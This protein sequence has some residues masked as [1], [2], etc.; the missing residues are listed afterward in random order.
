M[1]ARD[2]A[3]IIESS[4]QYGRELLAGIAKYGRLH[5]WRIRY[6]QGGI[7]RDEP[8]WLKDWQGDGVITR[9]P[10][11]NYSIQL[12]QKGMVVVSHRAKPNNNEYHYCPPIDNGL[13]IGKL[14]AEYF[15][16]KGYQNF[17]F[18]GHDDTEYSLNRQQGFVEHLAKQGF[19]CP[20]FT[21]HER[22]IEENDLLHQRERQF[23]ETLPLPCAILTANDERGA[24]ILGTCMECNIAVPEKIA[25]LGVDNDPLLCDLA[26][27]PL[28]SISPNV[29]REG[30]LLASYLD[31]LMSHGKADIIPECLPDQVIER[32]SS[33]QDAVEDEALARA[34]HIIRSKAFTGINI[35]EVASAVGLSRRSLERRFSS[36]LHTTINAHI[37]QILVDRVKALLQE[38]DYT[39]EHI[40]SLVGLDHMQRLY[41]LF[42][43]RTGMTPAEFRTKG[44]KAT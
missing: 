1:P 36:Q 13:N 32:Q 23:L 34:L 12:A 15:L 35:E 3:V 43:K 6:E 20:I 31:Q 39:I 22:G 14:A 38:T 10:N 11:P 2:I 5:D 18:I 8:E 16:N 27:P 4:T 30:W 25:V 17:A 9:C 24:Q 33:S 28:S 26:Y 7:R 42:K 40:A 19:S 29:K 41:Q 21:S 37:S 44:D